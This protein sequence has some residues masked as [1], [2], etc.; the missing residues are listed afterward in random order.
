MNQPDPSRGPEKSGVYLSVVLPC[1][2]E[3]AVI[4]ETHRRVAQVCA[5]VGKSYEIVVVNDGSKDD[6]WQIL[7][8][9]TRVD[10]QLVAI[11]LSRNHGHQLALSAGLS[12]TRGERI[13]IMDAD[14]QDPPELLPEML[15]RM[16]SGVDVVYAQRR[17]RPGDA[18]LKR[19]FCAIFYRLLE[20]LSDTQIPLDT[21]DFRLIS[22]RVRD[23]LVAMPERQRFIRGMVSWVG[24][25]QEPV[26]YDR[27]ARFAGE[28]KYSLMKLMALAMNGIVSSSLKPLAFATVLG[29]MAAVVGCLLLLYVLFS[30]LFVG[31]TPQGWASL[32]VTI[33]F[34]GGIQLVVLGIM[35]E[36]LGRIHEQ[37]RNR[38]MFLV[39]EIASQESRNPRGTQP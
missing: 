37:T 34:M 19:L 18:P 21:G 7:N 36:Y 28:S 27:D 20:K 5:A 25:R 31:R 12:F 10:P 32:L 14:L 35:G 24:F 6:T 2:N 29:G 30:W 15:A 9:L 3:S 11:N 1:Y 4:R 38:P 13:L 17:S 23:L 39:S 33:V 16:D 26:F 8:E 22:R